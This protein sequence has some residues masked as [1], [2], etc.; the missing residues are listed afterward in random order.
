MNKRVGDQARAPFNRPDSVEGSYHVV[1]YGVDQGARALYPPP[2]LVSLRASGRL[3]QILES[4]SAAMSL[5]PVFATG[6]CA[7]ANTPARATFFRALLH[8]GRVGSI[9]TG[10][11]FLLACLFATRPI[12]G[13]SSKTPQYPDCS[14][15]ARFTRGGFAW[16]LAGFCYGRRRLPRRPSLKTLSVLEPPAG[17]GRVS[18]CCRHS[19]MDDSQVS[20]TF[21]THGTV[22]L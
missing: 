15:R 2:L 12:P 5:T 10:A 7:V 9:I 6:P 18:P 1:G 21:S 17:R 14:G 11:I 4:G 3:C 13:G 22:S 16:R 19:W 20:C 8:C